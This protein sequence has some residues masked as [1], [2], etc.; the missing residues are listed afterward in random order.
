VLHAPVTQ[1]LS[2]A[3]LKAA[4]SIQMSSDNQTR[5]VIHRASPV[6]ISSCLMLHLM[7]Q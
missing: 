5:N 4:K 2:D 3:Q 6:S 7:T 1:I